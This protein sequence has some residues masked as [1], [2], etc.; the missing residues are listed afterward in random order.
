MAE[1]RADFT[2]TFRRLSEGADLPGA[3]EAWRADWLARGPDLELMRR[4]NPSV[5]PRNHRVEQAVAAALRDDLA[6]FHDLVE[7]TGQP[8]A[9]PLHDPLASPPEAG[10]EVTRTFCGT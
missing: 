2:L 6:P 1:T 5:I 9:A 3:F 10:E 4:T 8:F 7:A